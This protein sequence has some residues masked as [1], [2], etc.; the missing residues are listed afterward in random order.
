MAITTLALRFFLELAGFVAFAIAATQ[1]L[2]GPVAGFAVSLAV[3]VTWAVVVAPK[4]RNPLTQEQRDDVGTAVLLLG[5]AALVAAS[6][7]LAG[8]GLAVLVIL[9]AIALRVIGPG[10]RDAFVTSTGRA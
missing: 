8:I 5:A 6:L 1:L 10:A 3:V 4:A 2:G 7:P 9:N